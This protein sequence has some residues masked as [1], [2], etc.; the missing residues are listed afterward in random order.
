MT[1]NFSSLTVNPCT[2]KWQGINCTYFET[3][4]EYHVTTIILSKHNLHGS[5]PNSIGEFSYLQH[6][7]LDSNIVSGTLPATI[8]NLSRLISINLDN[9]FISGTI[10]ADF[11]K[12]LNMETL[13]LGQNNLIGTI[14]FQ[15]GDLTELQQ[16]VLGYN[17]L[18][19]NFPDSFE[20]L[21]KLQH[22]L[23][24]F[25]NLVGALP[26]SYKSFSNLTTFNVF[27]N[28][29]TGPISDVF[30][31]MPRLTYLTLGYN[32]LSSSLPPCL[33][34]LPQLVY[35]DL[36]DNAI[37]GTIPATFS[38]FPAM[39]VLY[40]SRNNLHGSMNIFC[41]V[42]TLSQLYL[43][44][45]AFSGPLPH[46]IDQMPLLINLF[47]SNN[48]FTGSI[49]AESWGSKQGLVTLDISQN[50]LTGTLPSALSNITDLKYLYLFG[51][52]FTGTVPPSYSRLR[53]LR[54]LMLQD[55]KLTGP[56][57]GIFDISRQTKLDTVQLSGNAF[58]GTLPDEEL[59]GP[60]SQVSTF[61]AV[62]NCLHGHVPLSI[63]NCVKMRFLALDGAG[64]SQACQKEIFPGLTNSYTV[65]NP[66]H[67]SIPSC[68]FALPNL[69]TLHLSGNRLTGSIG[70]YDDMQL[71]HKLY[72]L[73]LSHNV[74]TGRIP[75][76]IQQRIFYRLDLSYN[77]LSGALEA[78]FY[79]R[80]IV[81]GKV[82]E[83]N[84]IDRDMRQNSSS[85]VMSL[86]NNRLSG[87][88][89]ASVRS[90]TNLSILNGNLF[91]CDLEETQLPPHDSA[92]NS[93]ECGSSNLNSSFFTWISVFVFLGLFVALTYR[94]RANI[95]A[96]CNVQEKVDL[97]MSWWRVLLQP[98]LQGKLLHYRF[99]DELL[100]MIGLVT[101]SCTV[102]IV[103]LLVPLYAI[104]T[105]YY[106]T[107]TYQYAWI[108][109][110]AFLSGPV[111]FALEF[112]AYVIIVVFFVR[113]FL[114]Y[115]R[116]HSTETAEELEPDGTES[117]RSSSQAILATSSVGIYSAYAQLFVINFVVVVGANIAFVYVTLY[118]KSSTLVIAQIGLSLVKCFWNSIGTHWLMSFAIKIHASSDM[119]KVDYLNTQLLVALFN[120]IIVPC[121]VVLLVSPNCV[122]NTLVAP[123]NV[124]FQYIYHEC[125]IY[126][127]NTCYLYYPVEA[128]TSY[129]PPFT[130]SYQCSA[131]FI[132][133]YAPAFVYLG[134]EVA[135]IA[136]G[137]YALFTRLH[138]TATPA[139]W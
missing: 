55:N 22:L 48:L 131:A 98:A 120:N 10:P 49:P 122:Y 16:L 85:V 39:R 138:K 132:T 3:I 65:Q 38:Q 14:P 84:I 133:S 44:Y 115:M 20:R 124:S 56:I 26:A 81:M 76:A 116:K 104:C 36:Y 58:T 4:S 27:N 123:P 74:L 12:L 94:Y 118:G 97:C 73:S 19:G 15:L 107:V 89:P 137:F 61:L 103:I 66:L 30:C 127:H 100:D 87:E 77:R 69:T 80:T 78:D 91:S 35:L 92:R 71:G 23:L 18:S 11:G 2:E 29:L 53:H 41:E 50:Y 57:T 114:W 70:S 119:S 88:V 60:G 37:T 52:Y 5:L 134:V 106:G 42:G 128:Y 1:W 28:T 86:Q 40:L 90:L 93:Y 68:L 33:S 45:N 59:F 75:R 102:L 54:L 112:A 32:A 34:G 31:N 129:S 125:A 126:A 62:E 46:C 24:P 79:T 121:L 43:Q 130:Y 25:N 136:P 99:I 108:V 7:Q 109:S 117:S 63:C 83:R 21:I 17:Y 47:L 72:D 13:S 9:N 135:F 113:Q 51:N 139:T 110:A 64:S 101:G 82:V 96:Y 8:G 111:P 6:L 95:L 105:H 67:G